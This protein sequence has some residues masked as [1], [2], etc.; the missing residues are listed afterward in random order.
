MHNK[1]IS[2]YLGKLMIKHGLITKEYKT[3]FIS[4][5]VHHKAATKVNRN[6]K[7]S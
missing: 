3:E 2:S 6:M 1:I 7:L 5:Q 4:I